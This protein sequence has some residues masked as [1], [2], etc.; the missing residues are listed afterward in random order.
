MFFLV[1]FWKDG[2]VDKKVVLSLLGRVSGFIEFDV[3]VS[4]RVDRVD[5]LFGFRL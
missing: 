5:R 2:G 1:W 4:F 3:G